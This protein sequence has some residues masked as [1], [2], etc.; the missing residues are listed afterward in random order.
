M[1]GPHLFFNLRWLDNPAQSASLQEMR[2]K[3]GHQYHLKVYTTS[4]PHYQQLYYAKQGIEVQSDF[5]LK[6]ACDAP[7]EI[8]FNVTI[9]PQQCNLTLDP[10]RALEYIFTVTVAANCPTGQVVFKLL[11]FERQDEGYDIPVTG[12]RVRVEGTHNCPDGQM[13][14]ECAIDPSVRLPDYTALLH[15]REVDSDRFQVRGYGYLGERLRTSPMGWEPISVADSIEGKVKE[16]LETIILKVKA[17]SS[18]GPIKLLKWIEFLSGNYQEHLC[19]IIADHT[20]LQIPW[21]MLGIDDEKYLGAVARVV[22]WIPA[23]SYQLMPLLRVDDTPQEGSVVAYVDEIELG[24]EQTHIERQLLR[25][26]QGNVYEEFDRFRQH[27]SQP[28][29]GAAL[30]YLGCHGFRETDRGTVVGPRRDR[31]KQLTHLTLQVIDHQSSPRP[32]IFVNACDSGLVTRMK[33][34]GKFIGLA[35]VALARFASGYLGTLGPV[36]SASAAKIAERLLQAASSHPEGA[37]IAEVL[38]QLRA[39]AAE[40]LRRFKKAVQNTSSANASYQE[41]QKALEAHFLYTFM[42]VYYGN[43]LT[44]LKLTRVEKAEI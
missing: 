29:S 34:A 8:A 9:Q 23:Q 20:N 2:L 31:A 18:H 30:I 6:L 43:P 16:T 12:L 5:R 19:L 25:T 17:F 10:S 40:A 24:A 27:L 33:N 26:L 14:R 13:I 21:E 4:N 36:G 35:E 42:Y 39:E 7:D 38:R 28:L 11:Y 44:R 22:R 15:I 1:H 41:T 37:S 3:A 32:I